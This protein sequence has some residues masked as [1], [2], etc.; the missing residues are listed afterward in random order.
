[1]AYNK[2]NKL[3]HIKKVVDVY[4][5][6]KK[7]GMTTEYVYRTHIYPRF[8]ISRSSFYSYLRMPVLKLI[9]EEKARMEKQ[10]QPPD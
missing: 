8:M 9:R 3:Y 2:L 4:I 6:E 10:S 1:M 5:L 7:D